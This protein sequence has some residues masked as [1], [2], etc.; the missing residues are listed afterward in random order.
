[1]S[2]TMATCCNFTY[3]KREI[4]IIDKNTRLQLAGT[5]CKRE[6][7][8]IDKNVVTISIELVTFGFGIQTLSYL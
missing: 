3:S 7:C 5:L 6:M 4:C 8:I 2:H 1:M